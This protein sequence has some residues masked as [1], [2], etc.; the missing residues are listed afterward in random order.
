MAIQGFGKSDFRD[1]RTF[2][3]E[4]NIKLPNDYADFLHRFNGGVVGLTDENSVY[5]KEFE[6]NVNIDVLFG[7]KSEEP[8]LSIELWLS[9]YRSE[10][11]EDT[12]IVGTSYQHGFI[13]L[14]CSGEDA[15]V[16][17]WDHAYEFACSNDGSNTYYIADTFADFIK[18]LI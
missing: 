17:Y 3:G 10:M 2:E 8:E 5:I 14:L 16:Y 9:D 6:A 15:G 1:I 18:G 12:I 7:I 11:P 13:V 4:N